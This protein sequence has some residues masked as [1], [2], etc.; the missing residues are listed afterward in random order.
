M[1]TDP[2]KQILQADHSEI[3]ELSFNSMELSTEAGPLRFFIGFIAY[4]IDN[5]FSFVMHP[6]R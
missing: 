2:E 6:Q 3:L 1:E 4:N 5:F